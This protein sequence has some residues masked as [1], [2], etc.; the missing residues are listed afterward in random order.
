MKSYIRPARTADLDAILRIVESGR[1][2][3]EEQDLPQWQA[4]TGPSRAGIESYIQ[5]QIGYVLMVEGQVVGYA[6][7]VPSPDGAP[8]LTEG[9]YE[10]VHDNYAAIHQVAIDTAYRGRGLAGQFMRDM[11]T[12][13]GILGYQDIRIDTH[14]GNV[15]MQ[16]II[17]GTGF[18]YRGVMHLPIP[19]GE[20]LAYQML[21]D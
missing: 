6:A 14:R 3:L 19:N 16:K 20:R 9:K 15:I 11:V 5:R 8:P 1:K 13:A 10:G 4:G 18:T 21:L 12:V 17:L 7:L 2:F